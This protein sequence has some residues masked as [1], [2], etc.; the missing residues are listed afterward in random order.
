MYN[1]YEYPKTVVSA[2][3]YNNKVTVELPIDANLNDLMD[4]FQTLV[5]G[6]TYSPDSWKDIIMQLADEYREI[7]EMHSRQ[8][9]WNLKDE[10]DETDETLI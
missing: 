4:A 9:N 10:T 5:I 6:L 2:Q 3:A 8:N 7:E 1:K